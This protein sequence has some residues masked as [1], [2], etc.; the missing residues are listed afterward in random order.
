MAKKKQ[1]N[2]LNKINMDLFFTQKYD[3]C[4]ICFELLSKSKDFATDELNNMHGILPLR[5][6]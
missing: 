3:D 4:K 5:Y 6:R 1:N 2:F